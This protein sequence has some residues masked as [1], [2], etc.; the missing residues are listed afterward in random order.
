MPSIRLAIHREAVGA[1]P[2]KRSGL[3]K[4]FPVAT[5]ICAAA[6][7]RSMALSRKF[8]RERAA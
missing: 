6:L 7:A 1:E 3:G 5:R 8:P 2:E 4:L